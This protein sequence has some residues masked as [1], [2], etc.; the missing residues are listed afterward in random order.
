MLMIP[1]SAKRRFSLLLTL[2][3]LV[4]LAIAIPTVFLTYKPPTCTDGKQNQG[5]FGID[6][7][8]PCSVLCKSQSVNAIVHWQRFFMVMPG[9]Y[10]V[11]AYV[12]NPNLDSGA[13]D[14]PYTFKL[15]DS[16]NV[17]V[18]ER[19]GTTLIPPRKNFPVFEGAIVTGSRQPFRATFSFDKEIV[20]LP[21]NV[22]EPEIRV[23]E[24]DLEDVTNS[25][26]LSAKLSNTTF[27]TISDFEVDAVI[28]DSVGNAKAASKT[29]VDKLAANSSVTVNFSWPKPFDFSPGRIEIVP[30]IYSGV[31]Y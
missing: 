28:Y 12:E 15:Y 18:A 23:T 26:R 21:V 9:V 14:V 13:I 7:G 5:E 16:K 11:V 10:S 8:G 17:L 25:P 20:W 24:Q 30:K 1:W 4:F 19:T 29:V 27:A 6:C 2:F 31:N 3:V 22:S